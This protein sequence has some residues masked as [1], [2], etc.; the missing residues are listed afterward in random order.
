MTD[1]EAYA[2]LHPSMQR[3]VWAS[4]WD[5][6]RPIQVNS[7][8]PVLSGTQDV[9]IS[10]S[11]AGG[12]TEAAFLPIFSALLRAA[13]E[14][15]APAG[16]FGALAISPLKSLI[17]DQARRLT[18]MARDTG[19]DIVAWH[20]D[21]P[22]G[23]KAQAARTPGGILLT[24]PESLDAMMIH[25]PHWLEGAVAGLRYVVVDE[26]HVFAGTERG[27]Q[28]QSL[29][30]RI[31]LMARRNVPRIAL[32]ATLGDPSAAGRFLR[33]DASLPCAFP[34]NGGETHRVNLSIKEYV[35]DG[36]SDPETLIADELFGRLRGA[37]NLVFTNSRK[38]A[39]ALR[40]RLDELSAEA[41]VPD[42][43]TLHHGSLAHADREHVE[44]T[45]QSGHHPVTAICTASMELG[46]DIGRVKSVAQIGT[47]PSAATLRQRL[48][49]S[50]RRG[51]P[52]VLRIYSTDESRDDLKFHLRANLVQNIAVVELMRQRRFAPPLPD[53]A[54]LS[55]AVQ[56][57]LS[58]LAQYGSFR[59][60]E[61]FG[62]LCSRG[63]FGV[64]SREQFDLLLHT[65]GA[66]GMV[67][68]T[69]SG[70]VVIGREGE[71]L[72]GRR[73]FY[74]A[75]TTPRDYTVV[76]ATTQ[77]TLGSVQYKPY[78]GEIFILAGARWIVDAVEERSATVRVSPTHSKGKMMFEGTGP[79][80]SADVTL[81][82]RQV[83]AASDEYP[84]LDPSTDTAAQLGAARR[85]YAE[86]GLAST[87]F[88]EA[89]RDD[90]FLSWAGMRANRTL[91]LLAQR[92]LDINPPYDHLSLRGLSPRLVERLRAAV[93]SSASGTP[94]AMMALG[95]QLASTLPRVKKERGKFDRYLPDP[96]LDLQYAASRLD[97]PAALAALSEAGV[98]A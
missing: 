19:I 11:T 10:A 16:S 42:E 64:L 9:V 86:A 92:H 32:S 2:M 35:A 18:D 79:D 25:R 21:T 93:S 90:H 49:R 81:M 91:A 13:E 73:D 63:A 28:L 66:S 22:A 94:D 39:E 46:V 31:E 38:E 15:T 71:R 4:G 80:I 27:K 44:A 6:L 61:A 56:Q 68:T 75:F 30:A 97:V 33:P 51:E 87:S 52:S 98:D 72:V 74:S 69:S 77:R 78:Y 58:L 84:Y 34:S 1:N 43:F 23:A 37:N 8:A 57:T 14:G 45:L 29:L 12:K 62:L 24:T 88:V 26:L 5:S 48:G 59:P 54:F 3:W 17:N 65:L 96:L 82:M 40:L 89:G 83:L 20:G 36:R 70:L 76:D 85:W 60:D 41:H 50:G 53:E 7:V 67:S 55:T 95:A 47:A